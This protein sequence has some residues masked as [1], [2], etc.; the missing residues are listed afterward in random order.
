MGNFYFDSSQFGSHD[1]LIMVTGPI[2]VTLD[3]AKLPERIRDA[4]FQAAAARHLPVEVVIAEA[5]TAYAER[6][7]QGGGTPP[8]AAIAA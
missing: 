1:L 5:M 6:I 7:T 2:P 3:F 4:L 8:P